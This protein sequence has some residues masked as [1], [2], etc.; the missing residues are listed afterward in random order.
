MQTFDQFRQH[1]TV[2]IS[3]EMRSYLQQLNI[4]PDQQVENAL[5]MIYN[6]MV[7]PMVNNSGL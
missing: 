7:Q 6:S 2:T 5:R 1:V 3:P 4:N